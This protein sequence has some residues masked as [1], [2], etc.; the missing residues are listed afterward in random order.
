MEVSHTPR[1]TAY[2]LAVDQAGP[3]LEVLHS[4][5]DE[6]ISRMPTGS[7]TAMSLWDRTVTRRSRPYAGMRWKYETDVY[8]SRV[9]TPK[10]AASVGGLFLGDAGGRSGALFGRLPSRRLEIGWQKMRGNAVYGSH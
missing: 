5:D 6:R 4:L 3:D 2:R 1:I 9:I 8:R 10:R 7:R